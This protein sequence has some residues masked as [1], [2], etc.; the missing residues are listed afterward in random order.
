MTDVNGGGNV[1]LWV[2]IVGVI[3]LWGAGFVAI[4]ALVFKEFTA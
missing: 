1:W 3:I 4:V 2:V